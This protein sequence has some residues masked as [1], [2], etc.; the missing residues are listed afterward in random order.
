MLFYAAAFAMVASTAQGLVGQGGSGGLGFNCNGQ[1]GMC[2]CKGPMEGKDCQMML[3]YCRSKTGSPDPE[4]GN[5][6]C[7]YKL[8][9]P[10]LLHNPTL[11]KSPDAR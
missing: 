7:Y 3:D 9:K 2:V 5:G 10:K 6:Y 1:D 4:S 8:G 11:Q